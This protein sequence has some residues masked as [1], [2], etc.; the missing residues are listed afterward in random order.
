M[1]QITGSPDYRITRLPKDVFDFFGG[2][3]LQGMIIDAHEGG[4]NFQ[5]APMFFVHLIAGSPDYRITRSP[6]LS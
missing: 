5:P 3:T 2:A 6:D 1:F 4:E